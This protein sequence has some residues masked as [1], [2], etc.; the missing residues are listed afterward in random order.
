M[1]IMEL[2]IVNSPEYGEGLEMS[3]KVDSPLYVDERGYLFVKT[4]DNTQ[5]GIM[6]SKEELDLLSRYGVK[7]E[8]K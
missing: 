7:L 6:I 8:E 4:R 1:E 2:K 5:Y 3:C